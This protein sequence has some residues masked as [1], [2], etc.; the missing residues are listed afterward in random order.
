M[1]KKLDSIC[2]S[3]IIGL[4]LHGID[5]LDGEGKLGNEKDFQRNRNFCDAV[6]VGKLACSNIGRVGL[7]A[8]D[9]ARTQGKGIPQE[10]VK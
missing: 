10:K 1:I 7:Y 2:Y 4:E 5:G 3:S 8:C 6:Y 9:K